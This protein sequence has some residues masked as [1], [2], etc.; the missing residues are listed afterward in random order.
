MLAGVVVVVLAGVVWHKVVRD[1]LFPKNFGVVEPGVVYRSGW[2]TPRMLRRVV[3]QHGIRT[4]VSL[5]TDEPESSSEREQCERLG[6]QR[7]IFPMVGDGTG[8]PEEVA[9]ALAAIMDERNQPVLVHCAAGA[10]RTS[11]IAILYEHIMDHRPISEIYPESFAF[12]HEPSDWVL[13]AWLADN[14]AR[15]EQ[16]LGVR[17]HEHLPPARGETVSQESSGGE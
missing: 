5:A 3:N 17:C 15:V 11:T 16:L 8:E 10:Q 13:L 14:T 9:G 4:V 2:L 6:V 12:H 1:E 7:L